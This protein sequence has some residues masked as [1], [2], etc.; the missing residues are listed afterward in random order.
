MNMDL[1]ER[2]VSYK[3]S[4]SPDERRQLAILA[5]Q[6]DRY[7]G[8]E[9][10]G[11]TPIEEVLTD[12]EQ[13]VLEEELAK[14]ALVHSAPDEEFVAVT[15]LTRLCNLRCTYCH[16]WAEGPGQTMMWRTMV[17]IVRNVLTM[18]GLQRA[19]FVWHGGEVTMLK[20]KF[21]KKLIWLQQ[22]LKQPDQAVANA[23][24]TNATL[25]TE[26]WIDFLLGLD[27]NVGISI[28]GPPEINDLRRVYGDNQGSSRHVLAGVQTLR[29]AGI[30]FGALI[31]VDHAIMEFG[32]RRILDFALGA[33]IEA[34]TLLNVLP[35]NTDPH[36]TPDNYLP[37]R[38]YVVFLC[39]VFDLWW[40]HYVEQ[41]TFTDL[42]EL[43]RGVT[44][45]R[46][47][48]NCL[49][50]GNCH[51]RFMTLEANGDLAPCDKYRNDRGSLI[52]NLTR[53]TMGDLL[54]ASPYL[55]D[56]KDMQERASAEMAACRYFAICRG[57]CPHDRLL[58]TRH[59]PDFDGSCCGLSPLFSK[60]E[61]ANKSHP[62]ET[63]HVVVPSLAMTLID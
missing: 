48:V 40:P 57:G 2:Y 53:G 42:A 47:P 23:L 21:M 13:E 30:P 36:G 51:G 28:D 22:H 3:K 5:L 15:K 27:I 4:L 20:P 63:D 6:S 43:M 11:K 31:V 10:I 1:F 8:Q 35:E 18:K 26:E 9:L 49:W 61:E 37:Y 17:Q 29:A 58:S 59:L 54:A 50:S 41:I 44:G 24:Q 46:R 25:L 52:G 39:E 32:A 33:G 14:P 12:R 34:I 16:S 45:E 19:Q 60:M 56:A 7:V 62:A 55:R 38:D